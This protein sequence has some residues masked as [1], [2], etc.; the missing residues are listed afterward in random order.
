MEIVLLLVAKFHSLASS[1]N[2]DG[3]IHT[4]THVNTFSMQR[5]K[6]NAQG[7]D[8]VLDRYS[9]IQRVRVGDFTLL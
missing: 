6:S 8:F 7:L 1:S 2:S 3:R 4:H 5:S 9:V